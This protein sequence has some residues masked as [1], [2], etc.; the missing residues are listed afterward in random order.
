MRA[1]LMIGAAMIA[2][3]TPA[4]AETLREALAKAYASSPAITAARATQ[5]ATDEGVPIAR[6]AGLP[7]VTTDSQISNSIFNTSNGVGTADRQLNAGLDLNVPLFTGGRVQNAVRAAETRVE[8]G[9]FGLR[10]TESD[11]FTAVVGA[12]L[13]VIRDEAIVSLNQQN[14]RVLDTNL[15]ASNDRFE[16]G[17]LTRTDVAQSQARLAG[18]RAQLQQAEARL[19]TSREN[20]VRLVGSPPIGLQDP[21]ALP[22]LP[23]T[24]DAAVDTAIQ[25]NPALLAARAQ[26]RASDYDIGVA[27]AGRLPQVSAIVGGNYYDYLGSLNGGAVG[28]R[29]NQNGFGGSVGLGLR[30]PLFQGGRVGADVRQ[31]QARR[32]AA[33][34]QAT[35]AERQVIANTRAAFAV[36]RSSQEVIK[37]S[38]AAVSANRLSLEGVRAENSV[39]TRTILDILNAEQ[40][41]LNTQVTLVTARRDAYVA[42]FALLAA[43]GEAE[44]QDLGLDGGALYDPNINYRRVRR[45]IN[46]FASDKKAEPIAQTTKG[47]LAQ[48][49]TVTRPLDP[50][51]AAPVDRNVANPSGTTPN[52]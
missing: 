49:A 48:D 10:G 46:D 35:G 38:E 20:Y 45:S 14:V 4:G 39:G 6:S 19:I 28:V 24:S 29:P 17:D 22:N 32:S 30:L 44:A 50:S 9:Q 5:R 11:L 8:A 12:Y 37:S 34:E 21:P 52:N 41:L 25:N 23:A 42:G 13:D 2:L 33:I 16:V 31:A 1:G 7:S 27:K 40:E 3:A 26:M 43:M 47:T 15:R 18:A 51:V 36:H